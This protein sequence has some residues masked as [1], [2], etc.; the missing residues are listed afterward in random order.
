M[1]FGDC[2][3]NSWVE[4]NVNQQFTDHLVYTNHFRL[5][6]EMFRIPLDRMSRSKVTINNDSTSC[7]E[8]S[9]EAEGLRVT[10]GGGRKEDAAGGLRL[11]TAY[12]YPRSGRA[13]VTPLTQ[14]D[15]VEVDEVGSGE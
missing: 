14:T 7:R 9:D 6:L 8:I 4:R 2:G 12:R 1:Y 11:A 10:G 5:S 13:S 15:D 3:S